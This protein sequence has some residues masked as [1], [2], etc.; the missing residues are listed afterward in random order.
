M[1]TQAEY[2]QTHAVDGELTPAQMMELLQ[3]PEGDMPSTPVVDDKSGVPDAASTEQTAA[4]DKSAQA[5]DSTPAQPE[6]TPTI[7]AKDGVHT[8]PYEKLVE[9]R[10]AEKQWRNAA[11]Q[12]QQQLAAMQAAAQAQAQATPQQ[13]AAQA[14][15]AIR[16]GANPEL[17]G[18]FSEEA[19]AA[20]VQ[21][22]V[23]ARVAALE[24]QLA[25]AIAPLQQ[26]EQ[27][28]EAEKARQA[29]F[30]AHPDAASIAE[31][32]ELEAWVNSKPAFTRGAYR[33]VIEG[34]GPGEV[35]ELL[36]AFKADVKTP[37]PAPNAAKA[38]EAAIANAKTRVPSSLSDIPGSVAP[39]VNSAEAMA[40]M[41]AP[42]LMN[43]FAGMR[44]EQVWEL[45][46]KIS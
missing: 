22:L 3:L 9:A 39:A 4:D 31:S 7:L 40:D 45:I 16:Q 25:K 5:T 44:P 43:R 28:S 38:A 27:A 1:T 6:A 26:A 23:D 2:F 18:D 15:E 14:S 30:A 24:A 8:I 37:A 42:A 17:F 13:T 32:A 19:I 34:G 33:A 36:D 35:I 41:D 10:E 11:E 29:I 46:D 20:G 21:K 12:A